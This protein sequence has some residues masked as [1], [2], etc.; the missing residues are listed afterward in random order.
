ML[1]YVDTL[2]RVPYMGVSVSKYLLPSP[3]RRPKPSAVRRAAR[4]AVRRHGPVFTCSEAAS[5]DASDGALGF[6]AV[7]GRVAR[8]RLR[9]VLARVV[10]RASRIRSRGRRWRAVPTAASRV[11]TAVVNHG[12]KLDDF[13]AAALAG[14]DAAGDFVVDVELR[15]GRA[16]GF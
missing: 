15:G 16:D 7:G 2:L 11:T 8:G 9:R 10:A 13:F 3:G 6:F 5:T 12:G 14:R 1:Q 4:T